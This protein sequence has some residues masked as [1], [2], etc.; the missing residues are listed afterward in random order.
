[1]FSCT[2]I[3]GF[4]FKHLM[5]VWSYRTCSN[6]TIGIIVGKE[7]AIARQKHDIFNLF[8]TMMLGPSIRNLDYFIIRIIPYTRM[9]NLYIIN[10]PK[11][12]SIVRE[13][14]YNTFSSLRLASI[15]IKPINLLNKLNHLNCQAWLVQSS[16]LTYSIKLI[17]PFLPNK[18]NK[19]LN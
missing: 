6:I 13:N 15:W 18:L 12:P 3:P 4:I 7:F 5:I 9:I 11:F 2:F 10:V 17:K 1:M 8:F 16:N 14:I 19:W